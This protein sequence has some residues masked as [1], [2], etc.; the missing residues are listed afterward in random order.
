MKVGQKVKYIGEWQA[1][2]FGKKG[3]VVKIEREWVTVDFGD[4][5]VRKCGIINLE[6]VKG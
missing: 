1:V 3:K 2:L 5:L 6:K 4:G